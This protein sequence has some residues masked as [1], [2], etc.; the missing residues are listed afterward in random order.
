M[1][2]LRGPFA[3]LDRWLNAGPAPGLQRPRFLV[4]GTPGAGVA[5]LTGLM[6][7]QLIVV[8]TAEPDSGRSMVDREIDAGA[9]LLLLTAAGG[10]DVAAMTAVAA[11]TGTEPIRVVGFAEGGDDQEW[12][13]R[14]LAVRDGL[15]R[16]ESVRDDPRALLRWLE[17]PPLSAAVDVLSAAAQRR[18]P[19]VLDGLTATVAA[20][21]AAR[22]EPVDLSWWL[23]AGHPTAAAQQLTVDALGPVL[24]LDLGIPSGDGIAALLTLPVL[25]AARLLTPSTVGQGGGNSNAFQVAPSEDR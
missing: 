11:C 8:P 23:V 25:R 14:T 1:V 6:D 9:D 18:T 13:H 22:M 7:A 5:E 12:V 21:L 20:L 3:E 17:D 2:E 24:R 16:L 19:V 15:R 10:Q 4:I